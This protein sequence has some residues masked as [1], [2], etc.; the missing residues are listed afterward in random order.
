MMRARPDSPAL[1]GVMGE[2][3]HKAGELMVPYRF[4]AMDRRGLQSGTDALE[5]EAVLKDF[6]MA[7]T[8]VDI[9][10]QSL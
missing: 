3:R 9:G 8:A 4:M 10:L 7:P 5:T 6:G 2:H 1:I